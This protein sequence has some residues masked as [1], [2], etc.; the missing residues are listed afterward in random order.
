[1]GVKTRYKVIYRERGK[2]RGVNYTGKT[3]NK[4]E[5]V[6]LAG[7]ANRFASKYEKG[8]EVKVV[9]AREEHERMQPFYGSHLM[10]GHK[11]GGGILGSMGY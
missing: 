10:S 9:R 1:M 6:R 3:H 8:A 5:A 2:L 4:N 7:E 11:K